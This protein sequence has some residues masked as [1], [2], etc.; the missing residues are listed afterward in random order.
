VR[1]PATVAIVDDR[2]RMVAPRW[3]A[4]RGPIRQRETEATFLAI[5][6]QP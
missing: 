4:L 5:E 3:Q 2:F 6:G 1:R